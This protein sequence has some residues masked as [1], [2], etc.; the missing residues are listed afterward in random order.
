MRS[1]V[2]SA[3]AGIAALS[4]VAASPSDARAQVAI[5]VEIGATPVQWGPGPDWDGPRRHYGPPPHM[6]PR[7]HYRPPPPPPYGFHRPPPPYGVYRPYRPAY[8]APDCWRER[9]WV[10]T[11]WGPEVRMVRVCR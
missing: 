3:L 5:G 7:P 9:R 2:L 4:A 1:L 8:V 10:D 6:G 11:P